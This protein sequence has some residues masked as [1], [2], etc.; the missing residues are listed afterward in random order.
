MVLHSTYSNLPNLLYS[1]EQEGVVT[2]GKLRMASACFSEA[3]VEE[4]VAVIGVPTEL[5]CWAKECPYHG[6]IS[7][8]N[9]L[10]IEEQPVVVALYQAD[11]VAM[12][13]STPNMN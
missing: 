2:K 3:F 5:L 4:Y 10:V 6:L 9:I 1:S 13:W 12:I 7:H 11:V 8:L